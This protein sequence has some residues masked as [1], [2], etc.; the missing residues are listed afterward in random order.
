MAT[1]SSPRSTYH[2]LPVSIGIVAEMIWAWSS[3][4][5]MTTFPT[6]EITAV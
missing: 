4:D 3:A 5:R 2:V 6:G 1:G